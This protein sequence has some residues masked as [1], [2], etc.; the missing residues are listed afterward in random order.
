MS[1]ILLSMCLVNQCLLP[2]A[3]RYGKAFYMRLNDDNK[4][5]IDGSFGAG[6]EK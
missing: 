1:G 4:T 2:I 5:V 6:R 3:P